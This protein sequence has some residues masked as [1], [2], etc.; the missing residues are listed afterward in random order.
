MFPINEESCNVNGVGRV[1]MEG[2]P[3]TEQPRVGAGDQPEGRVHIMKLRS[4][5]EKEVQIKIFLKKEP[6]M[7]KTRN[8]KSF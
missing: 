1:K 7:E 2:N 4:T 3:E 6:S 8:K 5:D